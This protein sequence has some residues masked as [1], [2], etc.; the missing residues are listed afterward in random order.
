[1]Y[2]NL[3]MKPLNLYNL[4]YVNKNEDAGI[5][6]EE[7]KAETQIYASLCSQ[8]QASKTWEQTHMS[9]NTHKKE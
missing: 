6:P 7:L 3:T 2:E 5:R 1:M 4:I 9:I 8:R